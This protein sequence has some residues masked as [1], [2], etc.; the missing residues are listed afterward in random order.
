MKKGLLIFAGIVVI[1]GLMV[2]F[3]AIGL[4][5]SEIK[6]RNRGNAQQEACAAYFDK[7]WKVLQ[8][9]AQVADQYKDGFKEIYTALMEG[10]YS[11]DSN[12]QGK[13]T[14][15]KWIQESNPTFS[16][17]LYEKLMAAIEG[18]REGF[19]IEQQKLI[20]IDREHKNMR[21]TFPNSIVI[22]K[23]A[24]LGIKIIKSLKTDDVYKSGQENDIDLFK[25]K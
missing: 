24:D 17:A 10:R 8:Q 14:F 7:V 16:P 4:S 11:G 2:A 5:N 1:L 15:M 19:F 3:W 22:G 20:D 12:G 13:E 23:R 25:K 9:Q 21:M 18:Q 6:L